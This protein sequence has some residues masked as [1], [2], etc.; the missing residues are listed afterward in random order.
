MQVTSKNPK[1]RGDNRSLFCTI[2]WGQLCRE[3]IYTCLPHLSRYTRPPKCAWL[4]NIHILWQRWRDHKKAKKKQQ[5]CVCYLKKKQKKQGYC[6]GNIPDKW[7]RFS[8]VTCLSNQHKGFM[9]RSY[10]E[11]LHWEYETS[12]INLA[13]AGH[14][15]WN[16]PHP[17]NSFKLHHSQLNNWTWDRRKL[18]TNIGQTYSFLR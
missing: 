9:V 10:N 12:E 3:G 15:T 17:Q 14:D 2:F 16:S 5:V 6:L 11:R 13:S 7:S 8:L 1:K 4:I 18:Y